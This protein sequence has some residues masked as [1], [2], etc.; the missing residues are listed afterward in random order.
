MRWAPG[1]MG[2]GDRGLRAP[3]RFPGCGQAPGGG[4]SVIPSPLR[5]GMECCDKVGRGGRDQS[6]GATT[7]QVG[8][9][10]LRDHASTAGF[11]PAHAAEVRVGW[12]R[13]RMW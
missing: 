5:G 7:P 10:D 6:K 2:C 12:G 4:L 1:L 13:Q 8:G 11:G 9:H 3:G